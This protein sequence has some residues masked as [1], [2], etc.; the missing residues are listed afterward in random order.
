MIRVYKWVQLPIKKWQKKSHWVLV[1]KE[2][3]YVVLEMRFSD[4]SDPKHDI[5]LRKKIQRA[6]E[7]YDT[8]VFVTALRVY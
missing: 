6:Y 5:W 8:K 4:Y 3:G 2:T 1:S 7:R